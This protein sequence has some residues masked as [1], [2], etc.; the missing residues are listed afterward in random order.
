MDHRLGYKKQNYN[1]KK[2]RR[3]SLGPRRLDKE[4]EDLKA[5]KHNPWKE[6]L[7]IPQIFT[8]TLVI[9]V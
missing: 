9:I 5:E 7:I 1:F 6:N 4:T 8:E 3:T 2:N